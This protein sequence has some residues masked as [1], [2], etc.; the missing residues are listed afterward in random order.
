MAEGAGRECDRR[1]GAEERPAKREASR[2][3]AGPMGMALAGAAT[4]RVWGVGG[5]SLPATAHGQGQGQ[6]GQSAE[7]GRGTA[8]GAEIEF[9]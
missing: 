6:G 1:Q 9:Y 8:K 4:H 7:V 5:G 2:P 3:H